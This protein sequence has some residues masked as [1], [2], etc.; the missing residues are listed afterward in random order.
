MTQA[1][2]DDYLVVLQNSATNINVTVK[3][4]GE[5]HSDGNPLL[6]SALPALISFESDMFSHK[7]DVMWQISDLRAENPGAQFNIDKF[8][9]VYSPGTLSLTAEFSDGTVT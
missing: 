8:Y 4:Q 3:Y 5:H 6:F 1:F 9:A 7:S 2:S